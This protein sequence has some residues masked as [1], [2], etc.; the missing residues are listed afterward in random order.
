MS[1]CEDDGEYPE[2][3]RV[4]LQTAPTPLGDARR[5]EAHCLHAIHGEGVC[6][7]PFGHLDEHRP[8]DRRIRLER[9]TLDGDRRS[10]LSRT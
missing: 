2:S 4:Y 1:I 10:D 3:T 7:L 5:S 9:R 8:H 6:M